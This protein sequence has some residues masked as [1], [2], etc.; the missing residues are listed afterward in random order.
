MIG[1]TA[2]IETNHIRSASVIA[3]GKLFNALGL[4]VPSKQ[5]PN[6]HLGK[7]SKDGE[8]RTKSNGSRPSFTEHT[9]KQS[10]KK[11]QPSP[12]AWK[13][14]FKSSHGTVDVTVTEI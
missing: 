12:S 4:S 5:N 3:T 9:S 13:E 7:L 11:R 10:N 1:E 14:K 8:F 2:L 6:D